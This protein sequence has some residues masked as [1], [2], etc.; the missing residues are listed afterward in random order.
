MTMI[1]RYQND[2]AP[3]VGVLTDVGIH[4]LGVEN[5]A[6]LLRVP[7][8]EARAIVQAATTH[9][10]V[11]ANTKLLAPIDGAT[12]VWACGVTYE[13]SRDARVE[14]SAMEDVYQRVFDAARPE[15]F[16]KSVA[17]RVRTGGAPIAIRADSRQ[18]VPEPE[19]VLVLN[20]LGEIFG[21]AVGNDMSSRDIEGENPL[22]LPQAKIYDSSFAMGAGIRPFWEIPDPYSL[23]ISLTV[24]RND[25]VAWQ[26]ESSTE[27][28][29]RTFDDLAEHLFRCYT[30]PDGALL[31]TGTGIVPGLDFNVLPGDQIR[32]K[33]EGLMELENTVIVVGAERI[34]ERAT[35][36]R[37]LGGLDVV[38]GARSDQNARRSADLY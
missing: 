14:E 12:E 29:H 11:S 30:L 5:M 34:R 38:T 2:E 22:Y 10:P 4:P 19:L 7:T 36:N 17:W 25:V 26:G 24:T 8:S 21:Y 28:L 37:L 27:L 13:C 33:I 23:P 3:C 20:R 18:S 15:L 31:S 16:F 35:A 6:A 1:V 32:I 9:E